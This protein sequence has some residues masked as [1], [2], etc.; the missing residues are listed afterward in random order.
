MLSNARISKVRCRL[1]VCRMERGKA[2]NASRFS[3][4]IATDLEAL[5]CE[6]GFLRLNCYDDVL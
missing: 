6:L 3:Q 1:A 2:V 4:G 5:E